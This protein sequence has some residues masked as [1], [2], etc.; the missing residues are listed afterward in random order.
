VGGGSGGWVININNAP[1]G[2]TATVNNEARIIDVAVGR[3][4]A[5][6]AG[7]FRENSGPVWGALTSSSSVRGRF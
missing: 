6:I 7:E 1:P 5:E 3:A 4:K 2:T